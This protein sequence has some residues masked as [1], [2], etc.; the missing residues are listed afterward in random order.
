MEAATPGY[1]GKVP[2]RGDFLARRMAGGLA[3]AWEAWLQTLTV[4]VRE[5][6]VRGWQDKWLTAPLWHVAFGRGLASPGGAQGVLIASV[7]RVGRLFPFTLVGAASPA[8]KLDA[9]G[10]AQQAEALAL[11]ALEDGFDPAALDRALARLGPPPAADGSDRPTGIAALALEG[12]WPAAS[13]LEGA[14]PEQSAWWTRG[15]ALVPP[16]RLC[17][18]GLPDPALARAMILGG[19]E[20]QIAPISGAM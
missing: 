5:S 16:V 4:A 8:A 20:A 13:S 3:A 1:F 2:A 12:D 18:A 10:W 9:L 7:D 11:D 19:F 17:C 15:S 6:G 14:G